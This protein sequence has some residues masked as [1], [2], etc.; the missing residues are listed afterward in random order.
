MAYR[1]KRKESPRKALRRIAREQIDRLLGE[2]AEP[3]LFPY[4]RA[5]QVRRRC[6][7]MRALLR[8]F[9][10][11][12]GATFAEED[13]WYR[14]A[15]RSLAPFRD[16]DALL[17]TLTGLLRLDP[18]LAQAPDVAE[19]LLRLAH[20]REAL[21]E[22]E[23]LSERLDALAGEL[24]GA[25]DRVAGW[26]VRKRGYDAVG[27]GLERTARRGRRA[28]ARALA[29]GGPEARPAWRRQAKYHWLHVRL[30]RGVWPETLLPYHT[31]V[32]ELIDLLGAEHNLVLLLGRLEAPEETV[33][34]AESR[35][36][37]Q[38]LAREQQGALLARAVPLGR[39]IH[40]ERPAALGRRLGA[41]WDLWRS[42]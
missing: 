32:Q 26:K 29:E 17:E 6:K 4:D 21:A 41:Y 13:R 19:F 28:L 37:L 24:A 15:A 23:G 38:A 11:S 5:L 9:R 7:R 35:Q 30:L 3:S 27:P 42:A 14:D 25:R 20:E 1:V 12:L 10:G 8:L 31:S 22:A 18:H 40:A 34:G 16:A 36:A 2:L 33:L 39:R